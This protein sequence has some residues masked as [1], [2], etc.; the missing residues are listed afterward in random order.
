VGGGP[1]RPAPSAKVRHLGGGSDAEPEPPVYVAAV[2][3]GLSPEGVPRCRPGPP[4]PSTLETEGALAN[5][6]KLDGKYHGNPPSTGVN[7]RITANPLL[8]RSGGGL[9]EI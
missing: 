3:K 4:P 2:N 1:E 7:I 6:Q 8:I 5:E 9:V